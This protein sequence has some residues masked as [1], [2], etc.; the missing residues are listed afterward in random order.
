MPARMLRLLSLLQGRRVWSGAELSERLGVTDRT[1]RRDIDRLRELGYPVEGTTGTAGGYRLVS[2]RD[3]PPLVL[4]DDEAVAIA[5][6]LLTAAGVA[7]IEE[8][9]VRALA[10]LEQVLPGRLR[11]RVAAVDA[12]TFAMPRPARSEPE[13]S[14]LA[15]LA[16]AC[17]DHELVTFTYVSRTGTRSQRRVEPHWLVAAFGFWYLLAFDT[18]RDDWR[19]FRVDRI[20]DT[21]PI[22][23]RFTPREL[24]M[25][26]PVGYVARTV[27]MAP[28][29][30]T[31]T[32][33]VHAPAEVVASRLPAPLP[34]EV[35]PVDA[36]T[37]TVR[38]GA[39]TV[40]IVAASV[41]AFGAP[42]TIE[43]SP[44]IL[45]HLR[46]L[47]QRLLDAA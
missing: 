22:R 27:G 44:E 7:G 36:E 10:K 4:D 23:L 37:C 25:L 47:G 15:A 33:T 30:Y 11:D 1:V 32:A 29:R 39:D 6:G 42:F 12:A 3:L 43:G 38:L 14:A 45:A 16:T 18:R 5:V 9:A 19:T 8:T 34:G 17:R 21:T 24:P 20:A 2:G 13:P 41:V 40:E 26:D 31:A 28:Y 35:N 46:V